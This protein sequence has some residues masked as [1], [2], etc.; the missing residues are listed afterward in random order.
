ML[1]NEELDARWRDGLHALAAEIGPD[2]RGD[3]ETRVALHV[4]QRARRR[5]VR[6]ATTSVVALAAI[7]TA[8]VALSLGHDATKVHT[9]PGA[10]TVA[11]TKPVIRLI[12]PDD[13][14]SVR[15]NLRISARLNLSLVA[16]AERTSP[17]VSIT[18]RVIRLGSPGEYRFEVDGAA[19]HLI[20]FEALPAADRLPTPTG[21][22]PPRDFV[23]YLGRG[24]F[25]LDCSIPGH[26]AAGM[27][28]HVIVG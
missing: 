18:A 2:V 11:P 4:A 24:T 27:L 19:G 17:D 13:A 26:A 12:V 10:S 6:R 5:T 16:Q 9:V 15:A 25:T 1:D 21:S 23:V 22:A 8:A 7:I 3:A 14:G 20:G 28:L